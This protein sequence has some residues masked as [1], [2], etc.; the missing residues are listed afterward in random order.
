MKPTLPIRRVDCYWFFFTM[1]LT[2]GLVSIS[3]RSFA[4]AQDSLLSPHALKKLSLEELMNL[5][6]TSVSKTQ[7]KLSEVA[8]AIQVITG[9]D[10][11]RSAATSLPEA[12]RLVPNLQVAKTNSRL[13]YNSPGI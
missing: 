13:G 1:T 7:Q 9:E 12:L 5:E 3:D 8:S 4:Q 10:I 6:V 2:I 11:R